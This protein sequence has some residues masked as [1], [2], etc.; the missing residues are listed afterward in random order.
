MLRACHQ[1]LQSVVTYDTHKARVLGSTHSPELSSR[2]LG[3]LQHSK[4]ST[5]QYSCYSDSSMNSIPD[6]LTDHSAASDN[7]YESTPVLLGNIS[8][9]RPASL[10]L[11]TIKSMVDQLSASERSRKKSHKCIVCDKN[12]D[13]QSALQTHMRSHTGE[14]PFCCEAKG[15]EKR[16]SVRS[17]LQRHEKAHK[18]NERK[19]RRI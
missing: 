10:V 7:G 5:R 16:F 11:P 6:S 19:L 14:K 3:H 9:Q 1:N 2:R 12:F 13:R 4:E 8:Q 18:F 17:N 15:C